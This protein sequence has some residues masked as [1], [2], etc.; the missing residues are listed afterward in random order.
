M[1]IDFSQLKKGRKDN[2]EKLSSQV[3]K[4]SKGRIFEG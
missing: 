1:A 2:F 3:D 4:L